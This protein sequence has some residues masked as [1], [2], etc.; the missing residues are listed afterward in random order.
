MSLMALALAL[1]GSTA[2]AGEPPAWQAF[3]QSKFDATGSFYPGWGFKKHAGAGGGLGYPP[4][5]LDGY[6]TYAM[7]AS[8]SAYFLGNDTG[9]NS[10]AENAAE[11]KFGIVGL[12]WQLSMRHADWHH[13]E[14]FELSFAT[15][16]KALNPKAKVLV[17]RNSEVGTIVW[18]SIRPLMDTPAHAAASGLWVTNGAGEISNRTWDCDN[19]GI[20]PQPTAIPYGKLF[21]NWTSATLS[22]WWLATHIGDAIS[23]DLIDGVYFDCSCDA[24]PGLHRDALPSFMAASQEGFDRHLPVLAAKKKMTI[25][26]N[27]E[28]VAQKS[29]AADMARLHRAYPTG[30]ANQTFQLIYGNNLADFNQTL[31]AFLLL[32]GK[33]A[34]FQYAVIGPYE[35][36][37]EPCGVPKSP[38]SGYGPYQWSPMLEKDYGEPIGPPTVSPAGE[39]TRK[40]SKATVSL[41]CAS[42]K[43]HFSLA[44]DGGT[45]HSGVF[46]AIV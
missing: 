8:T 24:P 13:L 32:R 18:D 5:P 36:A 33:Y 14:K 19:C 27:G 43:A 26:W 15:Q 9:V 31:A 21:F 45:S 22:D 29:C 40:W 34:L 4:I 10:A 39:W 16:I 38:T 35:C 46:E 3:L 42:W 2:A 11:A 25:A 41:D 37:A 30:Y 1:L 44:A 12:G 17:S 7:A 23:E 20:P 28:H 6:P